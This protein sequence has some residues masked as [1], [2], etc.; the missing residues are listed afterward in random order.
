MAVGKNTI[1]QKFSESALQG[2]QMEQNFI[3]N[4]N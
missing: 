2:N 3:N 4:L 1:L